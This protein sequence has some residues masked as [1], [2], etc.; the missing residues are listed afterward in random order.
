MAKKKTVNTK[1]RNTNK[2]QEPKAEETKPVDAEKEKV[3]QGSGD[4]L[5]VSNPATAPVAP[6]KLTGPRKFKVRLNCPTPLNENPAIVTAAD[7]EEETA[8]CEF[9]KLNGISNSKHPFE[10]T[11]VNESEIVEVSEKLSG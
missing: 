2:A 4:L 11:E 5:E 10:I 9:C 1:P 3:D 8:R 6:T 7:G